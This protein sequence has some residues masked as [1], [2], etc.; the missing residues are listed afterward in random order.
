MQTE[1]NLS[2]EFVKLSF[3]QGF[4]EKPVRLGIQGPLV[5]C[6]F[7][8]EQNVVLLSSVQDQGSKFIGE[9]QRVHTP[10]IFYLKL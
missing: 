1:V 8:R 6:T 7:K 10:S 2:C 5:T 3:L 4:P 9:K